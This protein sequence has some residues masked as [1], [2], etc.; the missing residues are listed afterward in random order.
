MLA[1]IKHHKLFVIFSLGYLCFCLLTY[2]DYG[3]T[4]DEEV[5][6]RA[7]KVYLNYLF[8]T[9]SE[10]QIIQK[11]ASP[12]DNP[13]DYPAFRLYPGLI[14]SLNPGSGYEVAHLLNL[15]FGYLGFLTI[16]LLVFEITQSKSSI[17]APIL[18]FLNPYYSGHIPA[19][20]KDI[21]FA[22]LYLLCVYL[23]L[24]LRRTKIIDHFVL[25]I[26]LGLIVGMRL[27]GATLFVMLIV[28]T[29]VDTKGSRQ[30]VRNLLFLAITFATSAVILY[31]AWPYL[32]DNPFD[33]AVALVK[34]AES[35]AFW[36][37][38]ILFD[39]VLITKDQRPWYYLFT[40]LLYKTPMLII[41]GVIGAVFVKSR[42]IILVLAV[43]IV[44]LIL[45]L[46]IQPTI[47]NEMRHFLYLVP[48]LTV[49]ATV[50]FIRV[51]DH[52]VKLVSRFFT[53]MLVFGSFKLLYDFIFLHPYQYVYFNEFAGK[54]SDIITKYEVDYWSMSYREG[55][56][57]LRA[58]SPQDA[59]PLSVY[60]CNL[61]FGVK[62]YA[63]G[64]FL[65]VDKRKDA[66][67]II[68]DNLN[69]LKKDLDLERK[70]VFRVVRKGA[71]LSY[72]AKTVK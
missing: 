49:F 20:P 22:T 17:L 50:F 54:M 57:Y 43:I 65:I 27:V 61:D 24:K 31:V 37:R 47:Y 63:Q 55:S 51:T 60:P 5:N 11:T 62:Y 19:N 64:D 10:R 71:T 66:D 33:K 52:K 21:P 2:K 44:N 39:G 36:D 26:C 7:G 70:I 41:I 14:S 30:M 59:L 23:I 42:K 12:K 16:Y 1:K 46:V 48:L 15:L 6:Y 8:S 68:C 58:L 56:Q 29:M 67:Y 9:P 32:W 3:I 35:F 38:K 18:L 34:N 72:V 25:G 45:Y 4:S 13:K 40:Y 69:A 28:K 53:L